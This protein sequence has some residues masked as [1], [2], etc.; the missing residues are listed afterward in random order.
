MSE[1]TDTLADAIDADGTLDPERLKT[2]RKDVGL[3]LVAIGVA[4]LVLPGPIGTP[5]LLMGG[6]VLWPRAFERLEASFRKRCPQ[7][8][9]RS[10]RQ[11]GRFIHDIDRRYPTRPAAS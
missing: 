3:F 7:A 6:V 8:H 2:V 4:G 10:V 1:R 5:F 11:L 9:Q